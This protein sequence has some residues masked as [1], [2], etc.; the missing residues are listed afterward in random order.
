V[1]ADWLRPG[2]SMVIALWVILWSAPVLLS[3]K[4]VDVFKDKNDVLKRLRSRLK[5]RRLPVRINVTRS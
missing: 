3:V 4:T 2:S 5:M 1:L